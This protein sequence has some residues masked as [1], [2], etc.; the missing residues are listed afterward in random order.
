[1]TVLDVV[2]L[3]F[4]VGQDVASEADATL[5]N[6][7]PDGRPFSTLARPGRYCIVRQEPPLGTRLRKW[8]SV[9]IGAVKHGDA[10][11]HEPDAPRRSRFAGAEHA[12]PAHGRHVNLTEDWSARHG[13][14][15]L[16]RNV[17]QVYP[18]VPRMP[19]YAGTGS[20]ARVW[21]AR[22]LEPYAPGDTRLARFHPRGCS[23]EPLDSSY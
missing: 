6:P 2:G 9:G 12:T 14:A 15:P 17:R 7:D 20:V 23:R 11:D 1:V 8:D 3:H 18:S 16:A 21:R 19:G 4:P 22:R 13:G 10:I 5:S